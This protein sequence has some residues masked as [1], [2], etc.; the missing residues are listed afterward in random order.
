VHLSGGKATARAVPGADL[1]IVEGM[2]HDLAPGLYD[3]LVDAITSS[4]ARA[5]G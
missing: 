1:R 3:Q 2:G 4:A 5:S